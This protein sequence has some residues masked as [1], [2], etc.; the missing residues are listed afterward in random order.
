MENWAD[1]L[2]KINDGYL[3]ID[4][5]TSELVGIIEA[6]EGR[7]DMQIAIKMAR[8]GYT[9]MRLNF[10]DLIEGG[11]KIKKDFQIKKANQQLMEGLDDYW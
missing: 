10:D 7:Y 2:S 4:S 1:S 3:I 6:N 11:Q 5:S 8:M 9:I